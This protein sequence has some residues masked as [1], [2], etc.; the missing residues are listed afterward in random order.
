MIGDCES[1]ALVGR[2]GSID[3]LCWPR[4]DSDACFAA[5]LGSPDN[6]RWLIAPEEASILS[7]E[8]SYRGDTL[9]LDTRFAT[10]AGTVRVTDFM[11]LRNGIELIRQVTGESGSVRMTTEFVLRFGYGADVPWVSRTPDGALQ[12]VAGP[13]MVV[14]RTT[15]AL[16]GVGMKTVGEFTVAEGETVSFVMS[17]GRSHLPPPPAIDPDEALA[18][19]QAQ[20]TEW[21]GR[22]NAEPA[23]KKIIARSLITLKALIY[24]PTGGIVAAPTTSLPE[25]L[26]EARNW[27]YRFCWLRDATLTLMALMNAGFF[28]E[29]KAWRDWLQRAIAGNPAAV[30]I[31]YGLAGERRLSEWTADWLPGYEG[32]RPVRIGNAAA[33]QMQLDVYGEVIDS[34]YQGLKG[35]LALDA[36]GWALVQAL[37]H[38]LDGRWSKPDHGIWESRDEPRHYTHSKIMCWVAYDRA[39]RMVETFGLEG[40]SER[41]RQTRDA[42]HRD[43]CARG[44]DRNID[45]FVAWYGSDLLDASLLLV[46][47]TGFLPPDDPRLHG[48]IAAIEQRMMAGGFVLRHDPGLVERNLPTREGAFLAC[49]FWLADAYALLGRLGDAETLL[50]RLLALRNDVGLLA[51]EY[52]GPLG[53]QLGNFPQ[54]FSHVGLINT[55]HNLMHSKKP[56]EQRSGQDARQEAPKEEAV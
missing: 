10:Q 46:P 33:G 25:T 35:G 21:L 39:V 16:R 40:P 51:E 12:A 45:S 24:A 36:T 54:A 14:L 47:M 38:E 28:D 34:F 11:P 26:G 3:W 49:S 27:D 18:R 52:S 2:N 9:I 55:V 7:V 43:V 15:V 13:D 44:F 50:R 42:I 56:A 29:A 19:T 23:A 48:T 17:Y 22:S 20:W 32:S 6:G 53:R 37:L 5:L 8:R 31:M 30:Q 1:A 4:F 41:W